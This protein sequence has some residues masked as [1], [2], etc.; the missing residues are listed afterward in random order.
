LE[1]WKVALDE[2]LS[3]DELAEVDQGLV[4][5]LR[6]AVLEALEWCSNPLIDEDLRRNACSKFF[7]LSMRFLRL[8]VRTRVSKVVEG[9]ETRGF[10]KR[11]LSLV[12]GSLDTFASVILL[13]LRALEGEVL[14]KVVKPIAL[15]KSIA[16]P[17]YMVSL[18]I[19]E[20][21][22]LAALGYVKPLIV[23]NEMIS[24]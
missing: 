2:A 24:F 1:P 22:L 16:S 9:A 18:P 4:N 14:C 3:I 17:G 8:L 10:D 15:R 12:V 11:F 7:S 6:S 5:K 20:A 21:C 13:G 19:A 23:R